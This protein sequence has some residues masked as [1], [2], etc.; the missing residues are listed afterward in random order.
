MGL[1]CLTS[2]DVESLPLRYILQ[3]LTRVDPVACQPL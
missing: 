3:R 1:E 2:F